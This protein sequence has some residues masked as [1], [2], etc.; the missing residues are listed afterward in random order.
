M[1]LTASEVSDTGMY[2]PSITSFF[3]AAWTLSFLFANRYVARSV[4]SLVN[5]REEFKKKESYVFSSF[6]FPWEESCS[7]VLVINLKAERH[8]DQLKLD[9]ISQNETEDSQRLI[10]S[11]AKAAYP[12]AAQWRLDMVERIWIIF[13]LALRP[14][15][16]GHHQLTSFLIKTSQV[17]LK[18]TEIISN[19][20]ISFVHQRLSRWIPSSWGSDQSKTRVNSGLTV[21]YCWFSWRLRGS[22]Q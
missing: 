2:Q 12:E 19:Y 13:S 21:C 16:S 5:I 17:R 9:F 11:T 6:S 22:Y 3:K 8:S 15:F 14:H 7:Q 4:I 10:K 18:P 20:K 1:P